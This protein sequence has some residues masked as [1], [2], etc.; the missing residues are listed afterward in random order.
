[1]PFFVWA[2]V[3]VWQTVKVP[4]DVRTFRDLE[5]FVGT[6]G[7]KAGL[8]QAFPFVV[9]GKPELI[10]FHIVDAK[11]DTPSGMADHEKIQIRFEVHRQEATFV[12]FW[13]AQHQGIFVPMGTKIHVHFQTTDNKAS[14]HVQALDLGQGGMTLSLPQDDGGSGR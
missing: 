9:T 8:T 4:S 1:M 5:T 10:D 12:G 6:A 11:P 7:A 3:S 13:S 2:E 14:G